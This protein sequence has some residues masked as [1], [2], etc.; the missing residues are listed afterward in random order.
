MTCTDPTTVATIIKD[1]GGRVVG[2]TRLQKIAYLLSAA[3]FCDCPDFVYGHYGPYSPTIAV[4]A[5]SGALL[6]D[7][8]ETEYSSGW[9]GSYSVYEL[10]FDAETCSGGARAKLIRLANEA[11]AVVL[12]LTATAIFLANA[13]YERALD[14]TWRRKRDK[15]TDDRIKR[16]L[17]LLR[18]IREIVPDVVSQFPNVEG[19]E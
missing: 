17:Q 18:S 16:S 6:G 15:T 10:P 5:R 9:G 4:A 11:D 7:F 8:S 13:G 19:S 12:E 2:R 1:A 3:G 14:E